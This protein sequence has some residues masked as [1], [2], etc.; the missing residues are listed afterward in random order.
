MCEGES[1]Y[2]DVKLWEEGDFN[3]NEYEGLHNEQ[4]K[5]EFNF[6]VRKETAKFVRFLVVWLILTTK[7]QHRR[8]SYFWS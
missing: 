4:R 2:S 6:I 1:E 3:E 7:R 8:S 5:V